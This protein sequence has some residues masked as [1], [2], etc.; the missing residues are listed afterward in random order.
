MAIKGN[1][2]IGK[3]GVDMEKTDNIAIGG[4]RYLASRKVGEILAKPSIILKDNR[5]R[6]IP[7]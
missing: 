6:K 1:I 5:H 4:N 7:V 3:L 2:V